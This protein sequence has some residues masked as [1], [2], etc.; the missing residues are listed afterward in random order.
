MEKKKERERLGQK[1]N[2]TA[3]QEVEK[4]KKIINQSKKEIDR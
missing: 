1:R 4:T 2:K 3:E